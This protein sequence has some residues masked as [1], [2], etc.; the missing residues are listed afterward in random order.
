[1]SRPDERPDPADVLDLRLVPAALLS[2]L[3]V[4]L[5]LTA[6]W[7]V[8]AIVA[9]LAVLVGLLALARPARRRGRYAHG[10]LAAAG[11]VAVA[12]LVTTLNVAQV[13]RHPLRDA[14]AQG[15]AATVRAVVTGDPTPLLSAGSDGYG[16]RQGGATEVTISTEL[17]S[18]SSGGGRWTTGGRLL[19]I[20]SRAEWGSVLPGSELTASG[21]LAPAT[22]PDLTVAV[23][24]VRG[25][26]TDATEPP[27]WQRGADTLRDG[28]RRTAAS[29]LPE[30]PAQLLPG[31]AIGDTSTMSWT[32]REE[33]RATGLTH[34]VAVSGANLVIVCGAVFG[35][36]GLL[37][38]GIRTRVLVALL[39][40]VG[41]VLL[42]RP[43]PS[44][45]R[46]AVMG[47]VGLLAVLAGRR[48]QVI[49]ALAAAVIGLLLIDPALGTDPGFALSVLA[50]AA[51][52][53]LAPPWAAWL[54]AHGVPPGAAE[55]LA[56]PSAAHLVTAPLVAGLSGQ[57][58]LV[59][60][61]ANLLVAPAVAPATVLG[62]LA[63]VVSPASTAVAEFCVWLAGHPVAWLVTVAHWGAAVP[64]GSVPWP[65]GV[66]G[67]L[68]LAAAVVGVV[69][70]FRRRRVRALVVA[71]LLG[72]LLVLVPTRFATPG[73]PVEGW[74]VVACDVGQGDA[75][76]LA[77]DQP[78][79][80]VLV[81]AGTETGAVDGCLSR[82]GVSVLS[83][84]VVSHL[85]A[86]H[87]GGL[88]AALDGRAVGAVAVGPAR[89]PAWAFER[90]HRLAS[91]NR[92]PVVELRAGQRL[93]WPGLVLD[94]LGPR[95]PPAYLD[96][97]DGTDVNNTSLVLRATTRG[98]TVLLPG[99]IELLAQANLLTDGA[100]LRADVLKV[101]HHGSRYTSPGFLAA[102]HPRLALVSV[103]AGN[104][105][106]HPNAAVLDAL[107]RGGAL[108][109]RTDQAGDVAV[110]AARDGP[111]AVARGQPRPAPRRG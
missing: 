96:P 89:Q 15:S 20:A 60:V 65:A 46:A 53:L 45:L 52:V 57:V 100:L 78:G 102:V 25:P 17:V 110:V 104:R 82:L 91:G 72:A 2:W 19:L 8:S 29:V 84:V 103:G 55:A 4:I 58:S 90:V 1:M 21:L 38:A 63:A 80:A 87:V 54:R 67:A 39:A 12:G 92:V 98:G 64:G 26:P 33:F 86:D 101:P 37:Q 23:L 30:R 105:Y 95:E 51:L 24:R 69:V 93:S 111:V 94:V 56:V 49:P 74:S 3:V 47:G 76:V 43:S 16:G 18:A 107:G 70:M 97:E 68:L 106:G 41:F 108:V 77:T 48:R 75:L 59:A 88:G 35:L 40:L 44:V 9:G 42:A 32:L 79:R 31:L 11:C 85:H 71:A 61:V 13:T 28:L 14:A 81:D 27:W 6:G 36:L 7:P 34:L 10:L 50:T 73:W 66:G 62:V 22:R 83:L 5:G 99:D 109:R